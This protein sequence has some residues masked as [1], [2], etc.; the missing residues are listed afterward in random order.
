MVNRYKSSEGKKLIYDSYDKLLELWDVNLQER[1]VHT[2]FGDTYIIEVG[3][4]QNPPLLLFHGVGDNSALMWIYNIK[5]LSKDFHVIAIDTMGGSGKSE[6]NENYYKDFKQSTWFNEI[7]HELSLKKVFIVGVS[8]GAYL[9]CHFLIT[10]PDKVE[11]IICLAGGITPNT[12]KMMTVFLPEALFPNEKNTKKVLRKLCG[13]NYSV[14]EDHDVLFKHWCYLFKYFNNRSMFYHKIAKFQ[15]HELLLLSNKS[16]FLIGEYDKLTNYPKSIN[17]L[18]K[19]HLSFKIIKD[20]GHG[21]NHEQ[22]ELIN[23]EII[24]NIKTPLG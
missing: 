11:K 9:A 7:L 5:A 16:L 10:H 2:S 17:N 21:I 18:K 24:K 20:A 1:I 15:D 23:E 3:N 6:P 13:P 22:S 14:F 8:Y 4:H 19:N 12:F